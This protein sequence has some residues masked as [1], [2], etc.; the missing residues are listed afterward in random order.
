LSAID[1]SPVIEGPEIE[2]DVRVLLV[3]V[4]VV[5]LATNVSVVAGNVNVILPEKAECAGACN[6]A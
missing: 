6:A 4:S 5:V 1:T 3:R 2:G